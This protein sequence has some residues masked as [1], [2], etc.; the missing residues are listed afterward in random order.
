MTAKKNSI[1]R[2]LGQ[3][4]FVVVFIVIFGIY[5]ITSSGLTLNGVMNIFRHSAVIGIIAIGMGLVCLIGE[6]IFP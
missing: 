5:A 3:Y 6:S 1:S 2:I 4:S